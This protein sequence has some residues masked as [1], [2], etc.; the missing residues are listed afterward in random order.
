MKKK[1]E[2]FKQTIRRNSKIKVYQKQPVIKKRYVRLGEVWNNNFGIKVCKHILIDGA[3]LPE[4][5][6]H[7]YTEELIIYCA[8]CKRKYKLLV[9][10]N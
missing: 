3:E 9:M 4:D 1:R 2:L 7:E 6:G 10:V 8:V 5:I